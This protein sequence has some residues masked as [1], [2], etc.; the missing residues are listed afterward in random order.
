[1]LYLEQL[2][3]RAGGFDAITVDA[4]LSAKNLESSL[5]QYL[6]GPLDAPFDVVRGCGWEESDQIRPDQTRPIPFRGCAVQLGQV[7]SSPASKGC[8][9][10]CTAVRLSA[11]S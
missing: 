11:A 1:M 9:V 2:E 10:A 8:I 3:G 4:H 7:C 6:E 5:L